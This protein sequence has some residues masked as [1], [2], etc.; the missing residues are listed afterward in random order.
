MEPQAS[1]GTRNQKI[2][3]VSIGIPAYNEGGTISQ[4]LNAILKQP[5]NGFMLQ[6]IIVNASGS[7]DDTEAKV[8]AVTRADSRVKLISNG[9]RSGKAAALNDILQCSKSDVMLFLDADVV[10]EKNSIV[11]LI[12]PFLQNEKLGICSGNTMPSVE[13]WRQRGMFKFASVFIREFHH[14]LCSYLMNNGL[15]PK[16]NGTFYAF[17]SSIIDSFPRLVVS[18][19]EYVSWQAQKKGY[20]IVYVPNASV[21]TRDPHSFR[22]FIKWQS[23]IIAGQL[24]MKK[25]FNYYVPTM[26]LSVVVKGGLFKL[27]SKHRRKPL[28][29][30]TLSFLGAV[31]FVLAYVKF[32]RGDVPNVY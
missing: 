9:A 28:S 18:D 15:A 8:E 11:S 7:N 23:R 22:D 13:A 2:L 16:V 6:E 17:R 12:A 5:V 29:L 4:L 1:D 26:R 10:L 14:E 20:K 25:H 24:F 30:L 31:S 27:L 19:D 32:V 21:F 3:T